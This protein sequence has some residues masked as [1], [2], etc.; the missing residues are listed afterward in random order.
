MESGQTL[1]QIPGLDDAS[2]NVPWATGRRYL[3]LDQ[4]AEPLDRLLRSLSADLNPAISHVAG[5]SDQTQLQRASASPPS[6]P[7]P[8]DPPSNE[9]RDT[10][11]GQ[12]LEA[13]LP[14]T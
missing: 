12:S 14:R 9:D 8:L 5:K 6:E 4:F 1:P 3:L 7:D 2:L 13:W 11:H 10:F